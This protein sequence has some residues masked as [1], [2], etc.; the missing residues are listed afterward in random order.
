MDN[1]NSVLNKTL[2][3]QY[4]IAIL[5]IFVFSYAALLRPPLPN[6]VQK[7][8]SNNIFSIIFLF[9]IL[10]VSVDTAPHVALLVSL[11]FFFTMRYVFKT[12][13]MKRTKL[14]E[15]YQNIKRKEK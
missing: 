1:L 8:F 5:T 2:N 9:L 15:T 7:L 10:I 6:S 11:A 4:V 13:A 12:D 14:F 3:N